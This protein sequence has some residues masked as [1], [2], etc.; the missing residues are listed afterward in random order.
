MYETLGL[1]LRAYWIAYGGWRELAGSP[2]LHGALFISII[3]F[4]IWTQSDWWQVALPVISTIL[5]FTI[6][7]Y[8]IL[9]GFS[10]SNF[11]SALAGRESDGSQSPLMDINA[12]FMHFLIVALFSLILTTLSISVNNFSILRLVHQYYDVPVIVFYLN[13]AINLFLNFF[14]YS[15]FSY[16]LSLILATSF[17]LFRLVRDFDESANP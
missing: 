3:S 4:P 7:A 9:L 11:L 2:F 1:S 10:G 17:A 15:V 6:G 16:S 12:T 14:F 13:K 5:G 8:A